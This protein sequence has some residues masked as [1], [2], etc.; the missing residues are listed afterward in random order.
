MRFVLFLPNKIGLILSIEF[1]N[2]THEF[3]SSNAPK[4]SSS[5]TVI[6]YRTNQTTIRLTGFDWFLVR[7]HSIDYAGFALKHQTETLATQ[8]TIKVKFI[9]YK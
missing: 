8:A 5:I 4:S 6:D 1:G 7:F 3:D 9:I 2:W